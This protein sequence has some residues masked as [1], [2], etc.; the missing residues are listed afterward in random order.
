MTDTQT[1]TAAQV[2]ELDRYTI[3]E[4]GVDLKQLMEIAGMRSAEAAAKLFGRQQKIAVLAGPGGNG[5]DALVCAKWLKLWGYDPKV[6]LSHP[7]EKLKPITRD[8]LS[9][10][11]AYG[12]T[13]VD[14]PPS[15]TE[16]IVDGLL[17][18]SLE[19]APRGRSAELIQW[20]NGTGVPI[21]ALDIP[22]GM[23]ATTGEARDPCIK[24]KHTVVYGVMKQGLTTKNA[25]EYAG[26][27]ELIDIGFPREFPQQILAEK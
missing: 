14:D 19:G 15:D 13:V 3:K 26:E 10:W 22:S 7:L 27:I 11:E 12:G 25:P 4:L 17:G 18:Y 2:A 1:Y 21:L 20:A 16:G 23:D 24:A 5:G 6:L 9:I 8:Q